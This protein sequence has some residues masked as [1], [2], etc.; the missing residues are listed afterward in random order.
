MIPVI[1]TG[2]VILKIKALKIIQLIYK[3]LKK[4]AN[5]D[6]ISAWKSK[7][8]SEKSIKLPAKSNNSLA[9]VLIFISTRFK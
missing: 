5:S 2:K 3:Y 8:L 1:F 4:I 7:G 6:H 9:P